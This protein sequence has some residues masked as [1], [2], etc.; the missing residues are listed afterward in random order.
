MTARE[1]QLEAELS[2]RR[3]QGR[4]RHRIAALTYVAAGGA[5]GTCLYLARTRLHLFVRGHKWPFFV[6]FILM[7]VALF[8]MATRYEADARQKDSE[9]HEVAER[10]DRLRRGSGV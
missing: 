9:A 1:Q 3:R 10:L 4:W 5:F 7:S 6:L 2:L 8:L